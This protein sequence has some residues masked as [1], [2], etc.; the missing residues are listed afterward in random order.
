MTPN[1]EKVR[2]RLCQ[3]IEE[4]PYRTKTEFCQSIGIS[5]Q[6][7]GNFLNPNGNR[8]LPQSILIPLVSRGYDAQWLLYGLGS[9]KKH[10]I[11]TSAAEADP[12][13]Y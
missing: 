8:K 1:K 11:T 7:L 5:P 4:S 13:P 2:Q 10:L 9:P 3:I 12:H 6:V